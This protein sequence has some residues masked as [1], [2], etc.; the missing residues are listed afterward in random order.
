MPC[1]SYLSPY[2]TYRR[3][4]K[5]LSQAGVEKGQRT[6]V[7][8]ETGCPSSWSTGSRATAACGWGRW[9]TA[10]TDTH[11]NIQEPFALSGTGAFALS[12]TEPFTLWVRNTGRAPYEKGYRNTAGW[13]Q[14]HLKP[15]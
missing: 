14:K 4:K 6:E 12:G 8:L 15:L 9:H 10:N 7:Y 13:P 2:M 3:T 1:T 11:V 5:T